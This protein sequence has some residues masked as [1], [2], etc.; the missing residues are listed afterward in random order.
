MKQKRELVY[1]EW[2]IP[3]PIDPLEFARL[4]GVKRKPL[5]KQEKKILEE[6]KRSFKEARKWKKK[7]R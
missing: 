7:N 3:C 6:V 5:T 4:S 2:S 1:R